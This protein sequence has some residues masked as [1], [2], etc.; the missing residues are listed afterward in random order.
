MNLMDLA[1]FSFHI[2]KKGGKC[3]VTIEEFEGHI[4]LHLQRETI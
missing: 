3:L 1:L 4:C 2:Y